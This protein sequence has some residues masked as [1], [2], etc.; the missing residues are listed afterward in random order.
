MINTDKFHKQLEDMLKV[1][2]WKIQGARVHGIYPN[3]YLGLT[4]DRLKELYNVDNDTIKIP[5][6]I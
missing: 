1:L 5:K 3:T 4:F 2:Y 6:F